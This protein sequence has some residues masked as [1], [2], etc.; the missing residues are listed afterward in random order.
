MENKYWVTL[1]VKYNLS[2]L[3]LYMI[4]SVLLYFYLI[5]MGKLYFLPPFAPV[6]FTTY[7]Y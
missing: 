1:F 6:G 4:N 2:V 7:I 3:T 5:S